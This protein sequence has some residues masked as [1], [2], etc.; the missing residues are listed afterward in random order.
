[1]A[2]KKSEKMVEELNAK[3]EE[4]NNELGNNKEEG[5]VSKEDVKNQEELSIEDVSE[6]ED[7]VEDVVENQLDEVKRTT[8]I[9][10]SS[11]PKTVKWIVK[12]KEKLRFDLAIQRNGVWKNEQRSLFI[13]SII[14]GFPFP[15]AYA[16]DSND[17]YLW[18][19]D[20]KQRLTCVID[21]VL[22]KFKLDKKT[23]LCLG[24]N[25]ADKSF[26]ELPEVMR[27]EILDAHFSIIQMKNMTEEE[28]DEMF[29]RLNGGTAL[30]KLEVTRAMYSD[31][32]ADVGELANLPFFADVIHLTNSSR[33]R[34]VDQELVVQI[35][36]LLDEDHK[37]KGFGG[38]QIRDYVLSLKDNQA[39]FGDEMVQIYKEMSRYLEEAFDG[40]TKKDAQKALKKINVPMVFMQGVKAKEMGMLP[41]QYGEF[42]KWFLVD[43][44][45]IESA[46]GVHCQAGSAKKESVMVRLKETDKHFNM[47]LKKNPIEEY[48][49]PTIEQAKDKGEQV[50][51]LEVKEPEN[52][53]VKA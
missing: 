28:R 42:V 3:V 15:P 30:T 44:Y 49:L 33:N 41:Q 2:K 39:T 52:E 9:E 4:L 46:Y 35:A 21:F 25:I 5:K 11:T 17:G 13:H 19:L 1:M 12:N 16:M 7:E 14:Y 47:Y 23:P 27:D 40:M 6:T 48:K 31:L 29:V 43:I 20:G 34:F 18:F 37:L 36:M 32:F 26:E 53:A 38:Q 22:G 50:E 24:V 10:K 51:K 45:T 8:A